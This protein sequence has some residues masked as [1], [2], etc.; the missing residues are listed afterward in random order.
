MS[1]KITKGQLFR[2]FVYNDFSDYA[3]KSEIYE[4]ASDLIYENEGE[5]DFISVHYLLQIIF[6][7]KNNKD[8]VSEGQLAIGEDIFDSFY[9]QIFDIFL[10]N[11]GTIDDWEQMYLIVELQVLDSN[12][13][14]IFQ[15][16][17]FDIMDIN[18]KE[19]GL[20][21][22]KEEFTDNIFVYEIHLRQGDAD[23]AGAGYYYFIG[24]GEHKPSWELVQNFINYLYPDNKIS[25]NPV[26]PYYLNLPGEYFSTEIDFIN[27]FNKISHE[28]KVLVLKKFIGEESN[29]GC[30]LI[31]EGLLF[32]DY[33]ELGNGLLVDNNNVVVMKDNNEVGFL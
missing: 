28:K 8:K 10:N 16:K 15:S 6:S 23:Y 21:I 2:Y 30:F 17:G 27:L 9:N 1:N 22:S 29:F 20:E 19:F 4:F 7:S 18:L 12:G 11:H 5:V 25:V 31:Y 3:F 14:I 26:H 24:Y 33:N 13:N 32:E